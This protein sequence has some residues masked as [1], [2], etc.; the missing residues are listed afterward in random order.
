MCSDG[1]FSIDTGLELLGVVGPVCQA[2][3]VSNYVLLGP[4]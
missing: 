4:T 1:V 2:G 3:S